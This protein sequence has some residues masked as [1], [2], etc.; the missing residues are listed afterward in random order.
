MSNNNII[1][2]EKIS[3]LDIKPL[4]V[5]KTKDN[6]GI[7]NPL[8]N[9]ESRSNFIMSVIA[10]TGSGKSV[11]I[12]NLIRKYYYQVFDKI[13]FCSSNVAERNGI[14]KV[15]DK[16]YEKIEFDELRIF[17]TINNEIIDY[18]QKDIEADDDFNDSPEDFHS[19]LVID[20]LI[21]EVNSSKNKNI[22]KFVLK[23]RHLNCSVIIVS[24]KMNFLPTIIR[25]N[26][27]DIVLYRSKSK[28][29]I[30]TIYKNLIDLPEDKFIA[31]YNYAT[32]EK[33]HFLY[34]KLNT[35]PQKYYADFNE[36]FILN[37]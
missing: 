27:T 10:P 35:N 16:S 14:Q 22:I 29:E 19:L 21:T 2:K 23:S 31:I 7:P 32:K 24:H 36:E 34:S 11:L 37:N 33:H 8:P 5:E 3:D 25:N 20:D 6:D 17:P 26:L 15:Y 9:F 13:Y 30:E 4:H 18:I 1:Y 28:Q 12:S